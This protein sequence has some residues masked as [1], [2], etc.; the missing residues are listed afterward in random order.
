M[1]VIAASQ[2]LD[3]VIGPTS[4]QECLTVSA[5]REDRKATK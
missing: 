2:R 1:V 5:I 4:T 3:R